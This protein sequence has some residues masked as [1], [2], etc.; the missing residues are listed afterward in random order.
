MIVTVAVGIQDRPAEAPQVGPWEKDLKLFAQ[1]T[2]A[3]AMSTVAGFVYATCNPPTFIGFVSE[4]RD[5]RQY[6]KS[7][8]CCQLFVWAFYITIGTVSRNRSSFQ[9]SC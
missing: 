8:Y 3:G 5:F 2:F 9:R 6:K 4:M 1:P 7:M